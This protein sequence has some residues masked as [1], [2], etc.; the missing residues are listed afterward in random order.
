MLR[1]SGTTRSSDMYV[2]TAAFPSRRWR[3]KRISW[4]FSPT[5]IDRKGGGWPW[6]VLGNHTS[7]LSY[8]HAI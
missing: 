4:S 6:S 7:A 8:V 1:C 3:F 2:R 5:S